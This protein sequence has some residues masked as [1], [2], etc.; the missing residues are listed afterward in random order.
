[1]PVAYRPVLRQ[2]QDLVLDRGAGNYDARDAERVSLDGHVQL[3]GAAQDDIVAP[4]R[5]LDVAAEL[6]ASLRP[7]AELSRRD[8]SLSSASP[9]ATT[10][11]SAFSAIHCAR[12]R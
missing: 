5:F 4:G 10:R 9:S 12:R 11:G 6:R 7:E 8:T 3:V 1:M 2:V